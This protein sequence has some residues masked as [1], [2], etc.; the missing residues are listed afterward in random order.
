MNAEIGCGAFE[1][2]GREWHGP[3]PNPLPAPR[4]A[5]TTLRPP[6][7]K[8]LCTCSSTKK[9]NKRTPAEGEAVLNLDAED[10]G[11]FLVHPLLTKADLPSGKFLFRREG[12]ALNV[13][14]GRATFTGVWQGEPVV[15]EACQPE[16]CV[17]F[18]GLRVLMDCF[19]EG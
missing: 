4:P 16:R 2:Y 3:P 13:E 6:T 15:M 8:I 18:C 9:N 11:N 19:E 1:E 14:L 7:R 12:T 5:S 17:L 10:F